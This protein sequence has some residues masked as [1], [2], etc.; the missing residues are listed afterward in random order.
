MTKLLL[1]TCCGPCFL[2]VYED[3]Q[4]K[5]EITNLFYNPN[6]QP[7]D[8]YLKRLK[9]LKIV[10]R[11]KSNDILELEYIPAEHM[12]AI[13][14]SEGEFPARCLKCYELRLRRTAE[15]AKKLSFNMFSTTLLVSPYQKHEDLKE[16]G[17]KVATEVGVEFY[18]TDWRP[19][20]REGQRRAKALDV[21]RQK[22]CGCVW[23][24]IESRK[25]S[26]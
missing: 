26:T 18:Y 3:I 13:A 20:F 9:N 24:E 10:T 4:N 22:Y 16:I 5:F 1:H 15:T 21:Y 19:Y 12:R 14:G 7:K 23:S 8:E 25:S 6:I 11:D 2:G 17:I